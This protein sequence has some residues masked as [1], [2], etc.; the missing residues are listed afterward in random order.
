MRIYGGL[1]AMAATVAVTVGLAACSSTSRS[2]SGSTGPID[3]TAP[4]LAQHFDSIYASIIA[5][6]TAADSDRAADVAQFVELDPAYG[7]GDQAVTLTTTSGPQAW[8][9]LAYE[10]V[11]GADSEYITVLYN[12]QNLDTM[13]VTVFAYEN[14]QALPEGAFTTDAF[15]TLVQDSVTTGGITLLSTDAACNRQSS[16]AADAYYANDL[17]GA[18]CLSATL[19]ISIALV[20][21]AAN[22]VT[23]GPLGSVSISN[24]TFTG[25]QLLLPDGVSHVVSPPSKTAA[26]L[27]RIVA[28]MHRPH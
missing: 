9:G 10:L 26:A 19:D 7:L 5:G 20:F 14:E 16:L 1:R 18:T 8:R 27:M 23:L 12:D 6:G 11:S 3:R 25:V 28:L 4:Q 15:T 13:F 24:V 2:G 21:N 22:A 17:P